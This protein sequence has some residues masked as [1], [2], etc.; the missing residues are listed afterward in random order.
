MTIKYDEEDIS[1]AL[2]CEMPCS[3][4][5]DGCPYCNKGIKFDVPPINDDLINNYRSLLAY[6]R[7][8][9]FEKGVYL[10]K[11]KP[12][13]FVPD[14]MPWISYLYEYLGV[15]KMLDGK[16]QNERCYLQKA[17]AQIFLGGCDS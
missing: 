14:G 15:D 4:L 8:L 16:P 9:H 10:A 7:W 13:G 1:E 17:F 3:F 2:I 5:S 12:E 11:F 6:M